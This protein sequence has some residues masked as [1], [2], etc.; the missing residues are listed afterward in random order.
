VQLEEGRPD[1]TIQIS[2]EIEAATCQSLIS[3]LGEYRD[4]FGFE[5]EE[6]LGI[7][8]AVMEHSLNV[9]LLHK[10]VIQKKR[11]MGP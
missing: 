10:P 4:V 2:W 1:R 7:D 3:L 9:D 11:H 8:P 5:P 6:M